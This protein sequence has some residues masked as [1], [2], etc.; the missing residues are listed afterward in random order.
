[1]FKCLTQ[2]T[3]VRVRYRPKL[4]IC[5][6]YNLTYRT[7]LQE[8]VL[9]DIAEALEN[10]DDVAK[11]GRSLGF[12]TAAVNRYTATNMRGDRITFKGTR[13]MLLDWRQKFSPSEQHQKLKEALIEANLVELSEN[14]LKEVPKPEGECLCVFNFRIN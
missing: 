10:D 4:T 13:D 3:H 6:P 14:F 5:F 9:V 12:S 11:L 8:N 2:I 7:A 1:M